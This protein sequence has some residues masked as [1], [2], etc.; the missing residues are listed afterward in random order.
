MEAAA[1]LRAFALRLAPGEDLRPALERCAR[2]RGLAAAFVLAGIGSLRSVGLRCAGQEQG[3]QLE[4]PFEILSL[5]GTLGPDG[6]HLHIQLADSSGRCRGGHL[7]AGSPV[8]TTAELLIAELPGL[9]FGRRFDPRS[10][11]P[12]L[13]IETSG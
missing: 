2:E 8:F 3:Q 4:G 13:S 6:A 5:C 11:Y 1:G 10:G 7:L 9:A 12:E